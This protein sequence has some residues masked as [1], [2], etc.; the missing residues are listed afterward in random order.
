M[1][2]STNTASS[3]FSTGTEVLAVLPPPKEFTP[4]EIR[5]QTDG[6]H[7]RAGNDRG[8]QLAQRLQKEAQ[9]GLKQAADQGRAHDCAVGQYAAAHRSCDTAE[10]PMKPEQVPMMIGTLPPMGPM[11]YS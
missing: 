2:T 4:T 3:R 9:H 10:Y 6:K 8:Q 5:D 11:E 7:H 1:T